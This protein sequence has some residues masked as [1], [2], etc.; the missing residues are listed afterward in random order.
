MTVSP[1]RRCA[2]NILRD[3]E[4]GRRNSSECLAEAAE[5]LSEKDRNLTYE[6]VLGTLRDQIRLDRLIDSASKTKKL[7]VAVRIALRIGMF[8]IYH[9]DRVP[10]YSAINE[11]VELVAINGKSSAKAFVNAILRRAT[12]DEI[13]LEY[14]D[15]IDRLVVETSHPRWLIDRWIAEFGIETAERIASANNERPIIAFRPTARYL[16]L[17]PSASEGLLTEYDM[18]AFVKN[19]H[20]AGRMDAKLK[21]F[22][23]QKYIYFQDEA[24]QMAANIIQIRSGMRFLD[25]CASPGSKT[26]MI[27]SQKNADAKGSVVIAGDR[28]HKRVRFLRRNCI[29]QDVGFVNC[30]QYDAETSLPFDDASFDI[31]LVDA[32]CTGTGTIRHNPE[33]RYRLTASD[34]D[35]SASKQLAILRNA[36]KLI[37]PGGS[38]IYATCSLEFE[39]NELVVKRFLSEDGTFDV[40]DLGMDARFTTEDGFVRTMPFRD[41]M[42]GFFIA[43]LSRKP[44]SNEIDRI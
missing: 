34:I 11:S 33:I 1:A 16:R 36:A 25:L 43:K 39:E 8:Q 22:E 31:V 26:T 17:E 13:A 18:S 35:R 7:D 9:L 6:I 15:D 42:D 28:S 32:P 21:E 14:A 19:C 30:V 29:D 24:S 41:G 3:L 10:A 44:A 37:S 5:H 2:F 20:F 4:L 12:R 23:K 38:L 27:A 40:A